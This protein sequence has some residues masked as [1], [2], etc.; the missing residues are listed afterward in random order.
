MIAGLKVHAT[1]TH[2]YSD[3]DLSVFDTNA[4]LPRHRW[5]GLKEGF[6][7]ELVR[8]AVE[9][10]SRRGQRVQLLDPFVGSG[11][12][13]VAAGRLGVRATG[14]EVNPFLRYAAAAKCAAPLRSRRAAARLVDAALAAFDHERPSPL[15]GFS[16]FA[17]KRGANKWLFNRSALR[18][19][20][21]AR[22]RL[23]LSSISATAAL[24]LALIAS[25]MDSCNA[26]RDGKCLRYRKGWQHLGFDSAYVAARFAKRASIV[27]DD[28]A[29]TDFD[30]THLHVIEGDARQRLKTLSNDSFD[31]VV[32]SPPYLNS[33]DYSDVYRPELFAGGFVNANDDLREIRLQTIR[34]HVQVSWTPSRRAP[35]SLLIA[36]ITA[37]LRQRDLW[38]RR[39]PLMIENY[40]IDLCDILREA[41]RVVR[42]GGKA[43]VVVSTSAYAGIE[44]P[45]DLILADIAGHVGW[46]V[47]EVFVLRNL[48][49]S[50]QHFSKHL[51]RGT[52]PPLRESLLILKRS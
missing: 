6:S 8:I 38:N 18:G 36:P 11:T 20:E 31:L 23:R 4:D 33:F 50:G 49:A 30:S 3:A 51:E 13:V 17:P 41:R 1:G 29:E 52:K 24:H 46:T 5:Y 7:E 9:A 25:L 26:K 27:L 12:S 2:D 37:E 43:W 47:Q 45:V 10:A 40:F 21:A 44:I 42:R 14:I 35:S 15:E 48:R 16:T 32:T 39:L 28:L 19:F 34:S 22:T